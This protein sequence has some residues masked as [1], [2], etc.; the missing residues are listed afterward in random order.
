MTDLVTRA[1]ETELA[2]L[3]L[4]HSL[5]RTKHTTFVREP[6]AP[7]VYDANFAAF[8][9]ARTP[10]EI[11]AA[12]AE[13]EAEFASAEHRQI[14]WDPGT[15]LPFEARLQLDDYV[16]H[17][18]VVL[19]LE[20]ALGA[21][22]RADVEIRP[23]ERDADWEAITELC[24]LDHEEEVKK[25]FHGPWPRS[26]TERIVAC[27]RWKAPAVRFFVARVEGVDCGFFS[28]FPGENGVGL[29]EDLYTRDDFRGRGVATALVAACVADARARG[30]GPVLIGA[31]PDDTP[32]Q[33]YAAMGFRPLCVRRAYLR[34]PPGS[35]L[36]PGSAAA[37]A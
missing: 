4:G 12:I 7:E 29:V 21:R 6:R 15:P 22:V 9:R 20:G 36:R 32:K 14:F 2:W 13:I 11:D 16:A 26:I 33:M 3:A 31:R 19:A 34:V 28:G 18:E 23:A 30:A 24:W 27:K 5:R 10:A 17:D 25:G 8:P 37:P 35:P 1:Y